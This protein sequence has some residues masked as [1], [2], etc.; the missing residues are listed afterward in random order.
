LDSVVAFNLTE[1]R[2]ALT[3]SRRAIISVALVYAISVAVGAIMVH[4][5]FQPAI[6]YR[7]SLIAGARANDLALIA[8]NNGDVLLAALIDFTQNLLVGAVPSTLSGLGVVFAY[9]FIAQRGWVGGIVSVNDLHVSRLA[10]PYGALYYLLTLVLQL[11]PYSLA[12]G[13]GVNMGLAYFRTPVHYQGDRW[14]GIPKEAML[15]AL[16]VYVV[17][18]P[19]FLVASLWEFLAP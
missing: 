1:I 3:R 9:P 7:D 15:D 5:G 6:Q 17:I 12:G 13:V 4:A 16:R 11:V 2:T 18:V 8:Y 14:L 19:L 10:T